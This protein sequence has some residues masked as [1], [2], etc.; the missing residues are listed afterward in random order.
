MF[1]DRHDHVRW[2]KG[3]IHVSREPDRE[4][5]SG[6]RFMA[7]YESDE[8]LSNPANMA[9]YDVNTIANYDP[10]IIPFLGAPVGS[11]FERPGGEGVFLEVH[12]FEPPVD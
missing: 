10:E 11:A 8:Y 2:P 3:R 5:D 4:I 1:C 12:D 9:I 6:W 7:G